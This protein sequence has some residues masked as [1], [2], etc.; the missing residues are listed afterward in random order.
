MPASQA[1]R[2]AAER[3]AK[4]L[5]TRSANSNTR[6]TV[7]FS[8]RSEHTNAS[9]RIP[10]TT[11]HTPTFTEMV[12]LMWSNLN[13]YQYAPPRFG[14]MLEFAGGPSHCKLTKPTRAL[15]SSRIDVPSAFRV[16]SLKCYGSMWNRLYAYPSVL[17]LSLVQERH[18]CSFF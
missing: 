12:S 3:T 18:F 13:I 1:Q 6:N 14:L 5:A 9:I 17:Y 2:G 7:Q 4:K 11:S 15:A 16:L 10:N 8:V